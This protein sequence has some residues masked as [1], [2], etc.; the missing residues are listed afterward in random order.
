MKTVVGRSAPG[1][2]RSLFP[3]RIYSQKQIFEVAGRPRALL[4]IIDEAPEVEAT[5]FEERNK[6]LANRYKQIEQKILD[7]G[8]KIDQENRLEGECN[9]LARQIEQIE[10]SGHQEI[11]QSYRK[12]QQQLNEIESLENNWNEHSSK[13]G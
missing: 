12:R 7:L 3:V 9:Y 4:K 1:E 13:V 2:I 6:E 8:D 5:I 10:K 11:L